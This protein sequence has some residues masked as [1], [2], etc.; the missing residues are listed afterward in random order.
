[1]LT[2]EIMRASITFEVEISELS[3]RTDATTRPT[4]VGFWLSVVP[5]SE[6]PMYWLSVI[7]YKPIPN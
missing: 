5:Q 3:T 6:W 4:L 7:E 2:C 1:M